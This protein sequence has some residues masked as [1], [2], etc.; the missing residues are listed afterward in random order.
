MPDGSIPSIL[1][2]RWA[3]WVVDCVQLLDGDGTFRHWKYSGAYAD[4]PWI[5]LQIYRI[6][7]CKWVELRN[8]EMSS[9]FDRM[10]GGMKH[11]R[12]SKKGFSS[13]RFKRKKR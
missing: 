2:D 5:D 10:S 13:T 3:Y 7:R 4:Q 1:Y 12:G 8:N 6:V 11:K 9:K